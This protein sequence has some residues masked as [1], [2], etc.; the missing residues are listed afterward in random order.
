MKLQAK[1]NTDLQK[2]LAE[3]LEKV[4]WHSYYFSCLCPFH[5]N[6]DTP[7]CFVYPD[8]YR[9]ASCNAHGTLEFLKHKLSGSRIRYREG[10]TE[11]VSEKPEFD[12]WKRRYGS[13]EKAAAQAYE[14]AQEYPIL[15]DYL[16]ERGFSDILTE[17]RIGYLDG[18][19]S[20]PVFNRE[21]AMVDWVV[22]STP[23]LETNVK[24]A[25]RPRK[26]SHEGFMLYSADWD[27]IEEST[28]VYIPFGILDMWALH[29]LGLPTAT[30][31][32]GKTYNIKWFSEIRKFIYLIPDL[33]EEEDAHRFVQKLDWRGSVFELN[34]PDGCKDVADILKQQGKEG[35]KSFLLEEVA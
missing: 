3:Q 8:G 18:W 34:Y 12:K 26:N 20:F 30:G 17:G 31:L 11:V 35:L 22:R 21:G 23:T 6:R 1:A 27:M 28:G 10:V 32:T 16:V 5:D 2:E 15:L 14:T 9:C 7:A 4:T 33:N 25:V 19:I 29:L 13:Y 24:Y